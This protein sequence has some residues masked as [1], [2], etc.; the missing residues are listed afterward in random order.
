MLL[1]P[2]TR[3]LDHR[4]PVLIKHRSTS[5]TSLD[6]IR[7]RRIVYIDRAVGSSPPLRPRS[8]EEGTEKVAAQKTAANDEFSHSVPSRPA[9]AYSSSSQSNLEPARSIF[10]LKRNASD[11]SST[12]D[13]QM[14]DTETRSDVVDDSPT[15]KA[16][17][18]D[19]PR[20]VVPAAYEDCDTRDLVMLIAS[21]LL[22][23]ISYNDAI[24]L[25]DGHLTRFHSRA[26]KSHLLR[27]LLLQA[28]YSS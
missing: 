2:T 20:K 7:T 15:K 25:K 16:R 12:H 18:D 6:T 13:E 24:P 9:P 14:S 23:L 4:S 1:S 27:Q 5:N 8:K 26:R 11:E 21:M 10:A 22:E 17:A 3:T 28:L 19:P